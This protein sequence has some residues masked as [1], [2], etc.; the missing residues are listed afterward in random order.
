M[1]TRLILLS[2]LLLF[3]SCNINHFMTN[4]S[5]QKKSLRF[6][7]VDPWLVVNSEKI[8]FPEPIPHSIKLEGFVNDWL[9]SGAVISSDKEMDVEVRFQGNPKLISALDL[10]VAGEV[11]ADEKGKT[12]LRFDPLFKNPKDVGDLKGV[13]R[14][15]E[16]IY[17]FP[18][19]HLKPNQSVLIWITVNTK[20][21]SGGNLKGFLT[22]TKD[23]KIFRKLPVEV[24]IYPVKLPED[25][26]IIGHTWTV[27][28]DDEQFARLVRDYGINA[29]G[30]YDNWDMLRK[31]GFR[32]FRFSFPPSNWHPESLKATNDGIRYE[33]KM[34]QETISRL[35]LKPEEW[36]IEVFDEPCDKNAWI[37]I[38][39]VKRI[40][41]V[42]PDARF[43]ANPGFS[44]TN[45]AVATIEGIIEPLK[46]DVT[47]WCPY[48]EY[49]YRPTFL[50][51]LKKTGKPIWYY[52]IE[53]NHQKPLRGGR[54]HPWLAWRDNLDGWAFYALREWGKSNPWKDNWICARMYPE[55]TVS[56][57]MEGLRQGVQD[58]KRVWLLEKN[59]FSR[60]EI[61]NQLLQLFSDKGELPWCGA[62]P[63][64]YSI[65][66][67]KLDELLIDR[68][69]KTKKYYAIEKMLLD[70]DKHGK[71]KPKIKK[72]V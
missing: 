17:E 7:P 67:K 23:K 20:D 21:L 33:L 69:I 2:F 5:Q 44:G 10:K 18:I 24:T 34:I 52:T 19:L 27:Y 36:G 56:I 51:A 14:N 4:Y 54:Q 49:L 6:F 48:I 13:M 31:V 40:K 62:E 71:N 3:L 45:N 68:L 42:W 39:W 29:C 60:E 32:F 47:V 1:K 65:V 58:Y 9:N 22:L 8:Q 64:T 59:G 63:E 72:S 11:P 35:N 70:A 12:I 66:R 43:Y 26:P 37:F 28:K 46:N 55:K 41:N 16:S 15:W 30:Y 57:W 50:E 53:Y 38:E 61:I 25:N